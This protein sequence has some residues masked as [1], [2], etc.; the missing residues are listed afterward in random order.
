MDFGARN[1]NSAIGRWMNID[2]MSEDYAEWSP[3]NYAL[4]NPIYFIDPDGN[5]ATDVWLYDIDTDQL[6]W[7]SDVGGSE[8]QFVGITNSNNDDLGMASVYG[9]QVYVAELENSVF[10]S[11]YDA[12]SDIPAGYNSNT[13]YNYTG[14]D[15]KKRNELKELGGVFWGLIRERE[16]SG[17]A[18]PI[19]SKT[20]VDAYIRKW[21]T[22]SAFW[23]G[24]EHY[25]S[26]D[27]GTRG[28]AQR[29]YN[30]LKRQ[31]SSFRDALDGSKSSARKVLRN[32]AKSSL[33]N[34]PAFRS[35]SG[36]TTAKSGSIS[37]SVSTSVSGASSQTQAKVIKNSWNSF[38]NLTKGTYSG[39]NWLKKASSDYKKLQSSTKN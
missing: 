17:V 18:E 19:H 35:I 7:V 36:N 32:S 13:G 22:N 31:G 15:L 21:G 4:N 23:H 37:K 8:V 33:R 28:V 39:K 25:F 1:Y 10:V 24:A 11:S 34:A 38:L 9:S 29:G 5:S 20:G 2:N 3:Y 6:T 30:A 26:A 16:T 14:L 12:T 27:G